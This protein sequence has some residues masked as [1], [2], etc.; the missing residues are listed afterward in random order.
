MSS[1]FLYTDHWAYTYIQ[2]LQDRGYLRELYY[3]V[4]P[5]KRMNLAKAVVALNTDQ[6]M[7]SEKYWV[8]LLQKEFHQEIQFLTTGNEEGDALTAFKTTFETSNYSEDGRFESDFYVNPEINYLINHLSVSLRGRIDNGLLNDPTYTGEKTDGLAA[9]LE[10]G[11]GLLQFGKMNLFVGRVAQN[12]GPFSR[13]SLILSDNPYTYDQVGLNFETRHIAFHSTFAKLNS[14]TYGS[15]PAERYFSAHRLDIKFN[16]GINIG[17]SETVVY[18]GPNQSLDFSYMNPFTIFMN[19]QTNDGKEANENLAFDFFVPFRQFNF[20]GQILVDDFILDGPSKPV[21]NRKTS[22]DRLGFLFAVQAN[23]MLVKNS[24]WLLQYENIGS[25]TYNVKQKRPWQSYTY[26]G[27]GLGN[28]SNDRDSW[29]L[30][31]KYFPI[32]K[33]IFDLDAIFSRQGERDLS[34]N[35]FEDSSFVKLPFPSGIVEK[36]IKITA[37]TLYRYNQNMFGEVRIGFDHV[38]NRKHIKDSKKT[39]LYFSLKINLSLDHTMTIN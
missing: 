27:R 33:W 17:F 13:K 26:D 19:A 5:Y 11:Y 29:N 24:Q 22:S 30:N 14:V 9:R 31:V 15:P 4:K 3:S 7:L 6:L 32:P 28:I 21:P 16:G 37:G 1:T 8:K 38:L 2:L 34:A 18:G 36:D 10:D 23:D 12:W 25:Y 39:S 35:N 20:K